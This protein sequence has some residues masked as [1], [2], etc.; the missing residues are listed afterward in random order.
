MGA[1]R[2]QAVL[3]QRR[4]PA[5]ETPIQ[6]RI[7]QEFHRLRA[8]EGRL[9]RAVEHFDQMQVQLYTQR[10]VVKRLSA[11]LQGAEERHGAL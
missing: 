10:L 5:K 4:A 8:A 6:Q 11:E 1:A 2:Y 3:D 7:T 9:G